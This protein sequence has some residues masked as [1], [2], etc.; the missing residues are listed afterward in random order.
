M[1][2]KLTADGL[3]FGNDL[4]LTETLDEKVAQRL[5]VR[6]RT[7]VNTWFL[8][9]DYGVDWFGKVFGKGRSRLAVDTLLKT[10]ILKELYVNNLI[11]YQSTLVGRQYSATFSVK[12]IDVTI[13]TVVTLSLLVNEDGVQITDENGNPL[14]TN[15]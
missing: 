4:A 1:D 5:V 8:D 10:E 6:L 15:V 9:L 7:Y 3:A 2:I 13:P 12:L 11:S 14:L